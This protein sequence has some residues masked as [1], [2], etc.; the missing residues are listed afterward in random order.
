MS[1]DASKVKQTV[2]KHMLA[3]GFDIVF[4][5]EKSHGVWVHDAAT[6][7]EYLDLFTCFASIPIGYNHPKLTDPAFLE[8]LGRAAVNKIT[9]SDIY[10]KEFAD[11]LEVFYRVAMPDDFKYTFFIEGGGLAVENALKVAMD[12]KA[13]LNLSRGDTR[14]LP[15][16]V[17]HFAE[18]FHGRTGYTM[19]LTNTDPT[20]TLHFPKFDWPRIPNPKITFPLEEHLEEVIEREKRALR[21]LEQV[22]VSQSDEI[23]AI[24]IEPIQGEGGA[25]EFDV[26]LI[27]DEVQTGVGLTGKMWC[28]QNF[29]VVPD[30]I[31][32]GKKSQVCGIMVGERVDSVPDNVFK[33]SSRINSTWGGNIVDM[34]RFQRVLEII[35]EDDLVGN[36]KR[37]APQEF[38]KLISNVRARGLFA[39]FDVATPKMRDDLRSAIL[40]EGAIMLSCGWQSLR[41][42]PALTFRA[43]Y[44]TPPARK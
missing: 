5:A 6:G 11:F 7:R 12:W 22:L 1:I 29:S 15:L 16:K 40:D 25:D 23:C 37:T 18:C 30:I 27:F 26:M 33:R 36:V 17:I 4:D 35:E 3:D 21:K 31:A 20:K 34:V 41:L 14:D 8:R 43:E 10:S 39:A 2:G 38:P 42:R 44:S 24:I 28:Y 32:F 19:S 9:L 13:R